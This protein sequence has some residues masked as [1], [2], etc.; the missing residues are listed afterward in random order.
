VTVGGIGTT[1]GRKVS[2]ERRGTSYVS[3][4]SESAP[5]KGERQGWDEKGSTIFYV[6]GVRVERCP[7]KRGLAIRLEKEKEGGA[8]LTQPRSAQSRGVILQRTGRGSAG[9]SLNYECKKS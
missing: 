4:L 1:I 6:G 9:E 2:G 8:I 7:L 3:G 5:K